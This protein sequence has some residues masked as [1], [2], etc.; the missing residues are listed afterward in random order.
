MKKIDLAEKF[1]LITETW[2]PR[3]LAEL[4]GQR[5][6]IA[7][8]Q[9]EFVWHAHED[10]DELFLVIEGELRI[11]FREQEV[12]L[13]PGQLCVVPRGVEH[14]PIAEEE[15][16]VLLLE[17]AGTVNTGTAGGPRTVDAPE[18]I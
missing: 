16:Q 8:L 17:P 10:E 4:N 9:G 2:S 13:G 1:A 14:K 18:W 11:L 12:L 6:K 3:I 7:K 15:V 5:V